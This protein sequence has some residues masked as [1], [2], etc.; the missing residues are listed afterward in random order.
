MNKKNFIRK[1]SLY[2]H[3]IGDHFNRKLPI[4]ILQ[5]QKNALSFDSAF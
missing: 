4:K 5:T 2:N 3:L 1:N